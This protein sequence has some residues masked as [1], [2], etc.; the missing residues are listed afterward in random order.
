MQDQ[1]KLWGKIKEPFPLLAQM[2]LFVFPSITEALGI[3]LIEA[4][5]LGV[6]AIASDVG[7]IPE[8]L[9][10]KPDWL[11]SSRQPDTLAD[12]IIEV[13]HNYREAKD[14]AAK[15]SKSIRKKFDADERAAKQAGLYRRLVE[16]RRP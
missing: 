10:G 13:L 6:P 3:A 16:E 11:V 15:L 2:N 8:V 12:K 5:G 14:D 4:V 1:I 9:D 7:G